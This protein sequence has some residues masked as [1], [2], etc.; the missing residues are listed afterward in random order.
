MSKVRTDILEGLEQEDL[1]QIP[2]GLG[3]DVYLHNLY[4]KS[5]AAENII[6]P[7]DIITK[8]P[9][10]DP[11]AYGTLKNSSTLALAIVAINAMSP[12]SRT[13]VIPPGTWSITGALTFPS[14]ICVWVLNGALFDVSGAVTFNGPLIAGNYQIFTGAGTVTIGAATPLQYDAW[15]GGSGNFVQ[16]SSYPR[17]PGTTP[18]VGAQLVDKN[19]VDSGAGAGGTPTGVVLPYSG[20]EDATTKKVTPP[21][22]WLLCDGAAVNR[23]TYSDLYAIIGTRYGVGDGSTTFNLPDLEGR[24]IV[25]QKGTDALFDAVAE[26]GGVTSYTFAYKQGMWNVLLGAGPSIGTLAY[27]APSSITVPIMI[28]YMAMAYIIKY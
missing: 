20:L 14:N 21:S 23:V 18:T 5:Y 7:S 28:P 19:Y 3:D 15:N 4:D 27:A 22:G 6:T 10:I 9:Y 26:T 25:G 8:G 24:T 12:S 11:R 17:G 2:V 13:L 16:F 1:V